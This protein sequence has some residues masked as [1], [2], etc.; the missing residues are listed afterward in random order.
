MEEYAD[1]FV[2]EGYSIELQ[3]PGLFSCINDD[4]YRVL[5]QTQGLRTTVGVYNYAENPNADVVGIG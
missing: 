4:G 1:Q 2:A 5:A 3:E